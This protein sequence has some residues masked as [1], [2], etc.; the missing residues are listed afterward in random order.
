MSTTVTKPNLQEFYERECVPHLTEK[1]GYSN[2]MA[3]PALDKIVINM[4]LGEAKEDPK[5]V[6]SARE[7]LALI[8]GQTPKVTRARLA[9]SNFKIREGMAIGCAVTLR[10]KR[11]FEFLERFISIACPR[12]R[13]FRGFSPRGFDGNGNFNFGLTD[14]TIFPELNLDK[15]KKS[16]GMNITIV[17]SAK[18][19]DEGRE[20]LKK[21]GFPFR[22]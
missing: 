2:Q 5:I 9:V 14:Q 15:V 21:L 22:K 17:T 1:F 8:V 16:L 12:I 20:L 13:D 10:N 11:M 4:G 19:D 6:E 7:Q 3:V 18:T